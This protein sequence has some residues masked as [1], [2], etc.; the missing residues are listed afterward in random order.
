M[1]IAEGYRVANDIIL[2]GTIVVLRQVDPLA[3]PRESA[4]V[5]L[6][7]ERRTVVELRRVGELKSG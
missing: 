7:Y 3:S 6:N 4:G 2:G 5:W 1:V